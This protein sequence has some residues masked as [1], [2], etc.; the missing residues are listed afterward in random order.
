MI[1][2]RN[3]PQHIND[4]QKNKSAVKNADPKPKTNRDNNEDLTQ[5]SPTDSRSDEKVIVNEQ[6][7]NKTV[8]APSQTAPNTSERISTDDET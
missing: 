6:L 3:N 4:E 8:N 7:S 2:D 1:S 5:S